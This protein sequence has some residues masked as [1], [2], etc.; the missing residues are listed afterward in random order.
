MREKSGSD[1]YEDKTENSGKSV[2]SYLLV[3]TVR[4]SYFNIIVRRDN[5][6]FKLNNRMDGQTLLEVDDVRI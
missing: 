3:P 6:A 1:A 5:T 4:T 2:R